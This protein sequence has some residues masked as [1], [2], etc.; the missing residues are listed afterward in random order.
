MKITIYVVDDEWMAIQYFQYLMERT[1]IEYELVGQST[2]SMKALKE[3]VSLKPDVV[4]MDINMP[5]LDGLELSRQI[6]AQIPV[7][8]FL[9]TSYRDFD[10]V[11]RG[12]QIGVADYILKN[13]LTEKELERVLSKASQELY[14]EKKKTHLILEHNVRAFLLSETDSIEDHV[15]EHRSMQRY[16]LIS[17]MEQPSINLRHVEKGPKPNVDCYELHNLAYPEGMECSAFTEME[18][19]ELCG[20]FFIHGHV[21]DGQ[22]LLLQAGKMISRYLGEQGLHF[23]SLISETKYHFFELQRAYREL[24]QLS[25]YVYARPQQNVFVMC[26]MPNAAEQAYVWDGNMEILDKC[27]EKREKNE[28]ETFLEG[29]FFRWKKCLKFWEY[30]ENL[31]TVYRYLKS[32]IKKRNLSQAIMEIPESYPDTCQAEARLKGCLDLILEE[33]GQEKGQN[34]SIYVQQAIT[35]I[36]RN[37]GQDISVPDIAEAVGISEGHLRRLFKQELNIKVVDYLMEY[38]LESAKLLMKNT[39][40]N[41]TEIWSKTGFASAQY[42]SYV[43]K[44]KEGMLPKEFLKKIRNE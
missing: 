37:F 15:Y 38:R 36:H 5:V 30:T 13:E 22:V 34:Y 16:A 21:T 12:I 31:Q 11:K 14:G 35:Y 6:L 42:F 2:N 39:D 4:F 8:I 23:C 20:I 44:R 33:L 10:F 32:Y 3:I 24:K 26:D 7:K 18:S 19:G 27:L 43:F 41:L 17:V 1:N 40:E 29:L 25:E 9:L 28:A